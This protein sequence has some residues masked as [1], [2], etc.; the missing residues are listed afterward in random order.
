MNRD[1]AKADRALVRRLLK[2]DEEATEQFLAAYTPRLYRFALVRLDHN[3]DLAEETVQATL[4]RVIPM[5]HTYRGEAALFTWLCTICYREICAHYRRT[6]REPARMDLLEEVPE[7]RVAL[8]LVASGA[9]DDPERAFLRSELARLVQAT[10]DHLPARY[11]D[12]LEW[13]YIEGASVEEIGGRLA[14]G[15]TAAQSLLA[16]ARRAFRDAFETIGP[17]LRALDAGME[18]NR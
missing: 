11:G 13:K 12:A 16:R 10:L 7:I 5:L 2:G 9:T 17:S 4:L 1:S 15:T 6:R 18:T 8:E 14:I 3:P